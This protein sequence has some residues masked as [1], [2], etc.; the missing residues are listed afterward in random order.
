VRYLLTNF[1][2]DE[3]VT[4]SLYGDF[5]TG[6]WRG[7]ESTRI[8]GQIAQL[9]AWVNDRNEPIGVKTWARGMI[10]NLQAR[11]EVVLIQEAEEDR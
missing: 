1:G 10:A 8:N 7:N 3:K 11:L 9:T 6:I 5:I 2:D 4:S